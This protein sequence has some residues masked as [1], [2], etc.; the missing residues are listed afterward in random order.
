MANNKLVNYLNAKVNEQTYSMAINPNKKIDL[1][2]KDI[3]ND[4]N[5]KFLPQTIKKELVSG[6]MISAFGLAMK[7][8]NN[9]KDQVFNFGLTN[10]QNQIISDKDFGKLP[11][12]MRESILNYG[13][14]YEKFA[15]AQVFADSA[16]GNIELPNFHIKL[17]NINIVA[18]LSEEQYNNVINTGN[19]DGNAESSMELESE[20]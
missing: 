16:Q 11:E 5:F 20:L 7:Y 1:V 10:A 4:P 6:E 17:G 8:K 2:Q 3:Q 18:N 12:K 9:I 13:K 14:D 19:S 15:K